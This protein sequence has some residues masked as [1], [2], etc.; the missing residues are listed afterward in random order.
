M[1]L[2]VLYIEMSELPGPVARSAVLPL[3]VGTSSECVRVRAQMTSDRK[4]VWRGVLDKLILADKGG[5]DQMLP[6]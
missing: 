2:V 4:R 1:I 3:Q 6:G 5:F